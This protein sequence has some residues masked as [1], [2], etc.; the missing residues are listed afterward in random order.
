[1]RIAYCFVEARSRALDLA[2]TNNGEK[3][4]LKIR[5]I[6]SINVLKSSVHSARMMVNFIHLTS[7][8]CHW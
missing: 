7:E 1:M 2:E 8:L 4:N 5:N 6:K 3:K